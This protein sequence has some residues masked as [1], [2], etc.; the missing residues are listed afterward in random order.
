MITNYDFKMLQK[1]F[2]FQK[3]KNSFADLSDAF[4]FAGVFCLFG[5][6]FWFFYRCFVSDHEI[7]G[8]PT[9]EKLNF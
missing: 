9:W 3:K 8:S 2:F 5:F 1:I 6:G 4:D 7:E